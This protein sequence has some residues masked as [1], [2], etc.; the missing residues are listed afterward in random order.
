MAWHGVLFLG[1][2]AGTQWSFM[3]GRGSPSPGAAT[4]VWRARVQA[5]EQ[6]HSFIAL[7][8]EKHGLYFGPKQASAARVVPQHMNEE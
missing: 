5:L 8:T 1:E 6:D 3:M 7:K 4:D 2:G